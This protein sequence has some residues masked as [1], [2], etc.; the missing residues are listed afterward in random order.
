M[1]IEYETFLNEKGEQ[2]KIG[3]FFGKLPGK[4]NKCWLYKI[5]NN[6][7]WKI[8]EDEN[9]IILNIGGK[10]D[11]FTTTGKINKNLYMIVDKYK[12]SIVDYQQFRTDK[13]V[14][15]WFKNQIKNAPDG[16]KLQ[17]APYDFEIYKV[18]K[19]TGGDYR[20]DYRYNLELNTKL[21]FNTEKKGVNKNG[22]NQKK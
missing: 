1:T 4:K 6:T 19:L 7:G 5:I 14:I 13:E 18:G 22:F 12:A 8:M 15:T 11:I 10:E 16:T 3:K 17:L 20:T 9:T 21:I 2:L